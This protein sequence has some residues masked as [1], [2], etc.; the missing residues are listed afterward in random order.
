MCIFMYII[1]HWN[2]IVHIYVF[3]LLN[4]L[5]VFIIIDHFENQLYDWKCYRFKIKINQSINQ[6]YTCMLAHT[7]SAHTFLFLFFVFGLNT[8]RVTL[9]LEW[10]DCVCFRFQFPRAQRQMH[11]VFGGKASYMWLAKGLTTKLATGTQVARFC[12]FARLWAGRSTYCANP[13][14]CA[15][16]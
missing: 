14:P 6:F 10:G 5:F 1:L 8:P 3:Y 2:V 15:H 13:A 16:T 4:R 9:F 11:F 12:Q 7:K